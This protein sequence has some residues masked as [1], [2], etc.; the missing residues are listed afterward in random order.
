MQGCRN[1]ESCSFSHDLGRSSS[2]FSS[3]P[4]LPEDDDANAAS[5]LEYFPAYSDGCVLLLDDTDLHFSSNFARYFDPSKI[6]STTC[7]SE[8][9][10]NE[11]LLSGVRVLWGLQHPY[12]TIISSGE[13]NAVPWSEIKCAVWPLNLDDHSENLEKEKILVQNFFE[14]LAIRIIADSLYELRVIIIM[15]NL[16]FSQLQVIFSSLFIFQCS[17]HY[18]GNINNE[19]IARV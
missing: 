15:N 9:T 5:L 14:Y 3:S 6:V 16:R 4:C 18:S 11:R 13:K 10:I 7:L 19:I 17:N 12:Q 1:G 8:T 2:L